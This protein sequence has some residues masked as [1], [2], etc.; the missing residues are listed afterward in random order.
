M[1]RPYQGD[2]MLD[3]T[4]DEVFHDMG[5]KSE[6]GSFGVLIWPL[7]VWRT[8][9]VPYA[10]QGHSQFAIGTYGVH[11]VQ[12]CVFL[13][14]YLSCTFS[15]AV[16]LASLVSYTIVHFHLLFVEIISRDNFPIRLILCYVN[17]SCAK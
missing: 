1:R 15:L 8:R 13:V 9:E 5:R 11:T 10:I 17:G 7:R 4:P 12:R 2:I 3:E 14:N 6:E 16:K